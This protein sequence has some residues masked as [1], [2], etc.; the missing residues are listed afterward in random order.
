MPLEFINCTNNELVIV[1]EMFVEVLGLGVMKT[2]EPRTSMK[3]NSSDSC[4]PLSSIDKPCTQCKY[5][6]RIQ[7]L[8]P[9]QSTHKPQQQRAEQITSRGGG[10]GHIKA[11][12]S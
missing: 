6:E 7:S 12:N 1:M 11:A 2:P 5:R 4:P 9:E 10:G 3:F 8:T